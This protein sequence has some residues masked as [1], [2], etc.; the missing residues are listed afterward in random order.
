MKC[1]LP[2]ASIAVSSEPQI[3]Q[4]WVIVRTAAERPVIF[5]LVLLD[6]CDARYRRG[7][8]ELNTIRPACR[9]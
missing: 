1:E 6:G 7:G 2:P 3:A 5:A 4:A 8:L 9:P